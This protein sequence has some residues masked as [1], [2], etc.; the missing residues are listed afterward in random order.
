MLALFGEIRYYIDSKFLPKNKYDFQKSFD[1][2]EILCFVLVKGQLI[3][4]EERVS[5][6]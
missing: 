5:N 1:K 6:V 3:K 2:R 4:N